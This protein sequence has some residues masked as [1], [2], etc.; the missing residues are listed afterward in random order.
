V[1]PARILL[2]VAGR[3]G[4]W[5]N[6]YYALMFV[7]SQNRNRRSTTVEGGAFTSWAL[8]QL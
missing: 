5:Q 6:S 4:R 8:F 2:S 7:T 1:S 3:N